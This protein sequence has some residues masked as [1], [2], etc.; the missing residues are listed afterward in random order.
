MFGFLKQKLKD[1]TSKFSKEAEEA[2]EKQEEIKEEI[3]EVKVKQEI[4]VKEKPV[5]IE[6][7][8]E[9]P[10]K[11]QVKEQK[12]KEEIKEKKE[13]PKEPEKKKEESGFVNNNGRFVKDAILT[14]KP[15][16]EKKELPKEPEVKEI[17]EKQGF[18]SRFKEKLTTKQ[19]SNEKFEEIFQ[20]LEM[21]L[22]ESNVAFEVIEKIKEDLKENLV[23]QPL[24]GNIEDLVKES[25]LKSLDSILSQESFNLVEK[26]KQANKPYKI[27]FLGQNGAGKTTTISKISYLL[28]QNKLS[29]ILVAADTYRAASAEQLEEWGKRLNVKVIKQNYGA[30]PAAVAFDGLRYAESHNIDVVLIDTAGRQH[31]NTNLMNEMKKI[32]RVT[33]PDLKIFIGE[34]ITG[35]DVIFQLNEFKEFID[36]VILTKVDVDEKGGT[37]LSVSYVT[38]KPIIYLGTGQELDSL[39]LFNKDKI[40]KNL[41]IKD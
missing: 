11:E 18:F 19:I 35:N 40:L 10:K 31:S 30:D 38:K 16:Q 25:L 39:E 12:V 13:L 27:L 33:Q 1:I 36:A 8:K 23:N 17:K 9:Q 29:N 34:S 6:T 41:G 15:L 2:P 32:I 28:K 7:K 4:K 20:D 22:I 14:A 37:P 26:I 24:K 5:K 21:A 3:K